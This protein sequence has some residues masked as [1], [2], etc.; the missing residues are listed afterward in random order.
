M[1]QW[2]SGFI[3]VVLVLFLIMITSITALAA[4]GTG[5]S[6]DECKSPPN[7][8]EMFQMCENEYQKIQIKQFDL[9]PFLQ[10]APC[11]SGGFGVKY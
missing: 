11:L 4:N 5:P 7:I 8:K 1:F 9:K 2:K 6:G 3:K 10:S